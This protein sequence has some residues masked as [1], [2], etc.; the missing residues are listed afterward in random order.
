MFTICLVYAA[1][2]CG[3]TFGYLADDVNRKNWWK[4]L[5]LVLAGPGLLPYA[6]AR[7]LISVANQKLP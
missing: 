6:V 4:C 3:F 2:C 1:T 7:W 5:V